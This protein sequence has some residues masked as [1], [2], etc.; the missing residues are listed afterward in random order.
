MSVK[1][2]GILRQHALSL[3]KS[4]AEGVCILLAHSITS[5]MPQLI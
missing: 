2:F 4:N 1:I 3:P 5:V